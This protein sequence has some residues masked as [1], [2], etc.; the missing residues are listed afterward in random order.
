MDQTGS[1][2]IF[3]NDKT[4]FIIKLTNWLIELTIRGVNYLDLGCGQ[5]LV[6]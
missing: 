4:I 6:S 2:S 5:R 1:L 3:Q